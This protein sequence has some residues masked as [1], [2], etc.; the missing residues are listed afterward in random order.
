LRFRV[1]IDEGFTIEPW[2][3]VAKLLGSPTTTV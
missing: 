1:T 3:G 2:F